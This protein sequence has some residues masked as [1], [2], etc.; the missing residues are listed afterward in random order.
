MHEVSHQHAPD[1]EYGQY[2]TKGDA[3]H[4]RERHFE[5]VITTAGTTDRRNGSSFVYRNPFF[6][7]V[8]AQDFNSF[9]FGTEHISIFSHTGIGKG[10]HAGV[11]NLARLQAE[12]EQ[13]VR[14]LLRPDRDAAAFARLKA[15]DPA[16]AMALEE[17]VIRIL[18]DRLTFA[19]RKVAALQ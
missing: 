4:Q 6:F 1:A 5:S 3:L 10:L 18:A 9:G 7:R 12:D 15:E 11:G 13:A 8:H 14:R 17:L 16:A 2:H 19:N